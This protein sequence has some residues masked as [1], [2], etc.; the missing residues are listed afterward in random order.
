MLLIYYLK[1]IATVK[2][3]PTSHAMSG[4]AYREHPFSLSF[5]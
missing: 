5:K 4:P 3:W 1:G 2:E